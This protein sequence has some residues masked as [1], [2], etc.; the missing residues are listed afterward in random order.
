MQR[1]ES[2]ANESPAPLGGR[3]T[4]GSTAACEDADDVVM[5]PPAKRAKMLK[6]NRYRYSYKEDHTRAY[7][8]RISAR[9]SRT[10][11]VESLQCMFCVVFGREAKS[12]AKRRAT[13]N[14]KFFKKPFRPDN[15]VAHLTTTHAKLWSEYKSLSDEDKD[16]YM[17]SPVPVT[18][19]MLAHV[20]TTE[21]LR[22]TIC[23]DIVENLIGGLLFDADEDC[24]TRETALKAFTLAEPSMASLS[25][26]EKDYTVHIAQIR[27]FMLCIGFVGHSAS[28]RQ[29][30]HMLQL[31][32]EVTGLSSL[33]C[34]TE[35]QVATYARIVCAVNLQKLR[36]M[37]VKS[38]AS[39]VS[40]DTSTVEGTGFMDVRIRVCY[41]GKLINAHALA[42]PLRDRHTGEVMFNECSKLLDYICP[43]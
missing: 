9:N 10:G 33:G 30:A 16:A 18:N 38:W 29:T 22:F 14:T 36:E 15:F 26:S 7:G 28:F 21:A 12:G 8:L 40:L 27:Q 17:T 6:V 23:G 25:V 13:E 41:K 3:S 42:L 20:E 43:G 24:V 1:A 5:E 39:S 34:V 31:T 19:T 32:K 4:A 2:N 37:Q 11:H 35:M